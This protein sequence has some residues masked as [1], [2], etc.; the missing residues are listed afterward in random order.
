MSFLCPL[1]CEVDAFGFWDACFVDVGDDVVAVF[2]V[3]YV[4]GVYACPAVV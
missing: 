3:V 1:L 4:D 2:C